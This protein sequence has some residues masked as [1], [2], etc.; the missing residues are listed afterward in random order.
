MDENAVYNEEELLSQL[1]VGNQI[2]FTSIYMRHHDGLYN[3]LLKFTKNPA[4]TEDFVHDIFLKV[5]EKRET[6]NIK[7]SFTS[8]FWMLPGKRNHDWM[9]S[10]KMV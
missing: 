5:W 7:F 1:Y 3:Y 4:I 8:Y 6:M 2:A 9:P 10:I